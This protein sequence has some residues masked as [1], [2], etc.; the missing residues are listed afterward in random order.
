M[1]EERKKFNRFRQ[2]EKTLL[3]HQKAID[4]VKILDVQR[5][6]M[7]VFSFFPIKI[8]SFVEGEFRISPNSGLFFVQG[9]VISLREKENGWE[10]DI[11][12][13]KIF[14]T[15]S[16][17]KETNQ[18]FLN[19]AKE[20]PKEKKTEES[21]VEVSKQ[22]RRLV[23]EIISFED[24]IILSSQTSA[25]IISE[26]SNLIPQ[27]VQKVEKA[28]RAMEETATI[29]QEI[30]SASKEVS[31]GIQKMSTSIKEMVSATNEIVNTTNQLKELIGQY[32]AKGFRL[33]KKLYI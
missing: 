1:R 17:A 11:K 8:G 26:T 5:G 31:S 16:L 10:V 15:T 2:N 30:K 7:R 22:V 20:I 13:K 4:N 28:S 32:M 12:F 9:K 14:S 24:E 23:E 3:A 21:F 6:V 25:K 27:Q 29:A 33:K 18:I 19:P